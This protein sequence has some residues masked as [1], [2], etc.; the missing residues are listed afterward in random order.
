M[1]CDQCGVDKA[2]TVLY[3][4]TLTRI[5]RRG[6]ETGDRKERRLCVPCGAGLSPDE[7]TP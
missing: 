4:I 6:R 7:V 3:G 2:I 1:T 5:D